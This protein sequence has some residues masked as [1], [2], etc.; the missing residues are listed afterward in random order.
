MNEMNVEGLEQAIIE[1]AETLAS[2]YLERAERSRNEILDDAREHLRVR[3]DREVQISKQLAERD[4]A[5]RIQASELKF[6]RKLDMLR[7]SLVQAVLAQLNERLQAL[8]QKQTD[9]YRQLLGGFI[10]E[11][12]D[13]LPA[14]KLIA[15]LNTAD[16]EALAPQWAEFVK[17]YAGNRQLALHGEPIETIG[18]ILIS[19]ADN[20][21]RVDNRFEG[22]IEHMSEELHQVIMERLFSSLEQLGNLRIT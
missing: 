13:V 15:Y 6:Q 18:G 22:R 3:E 1:R 2:E 12:C 17:P 9:D 4:Y 7:W 5:R 11:A 19:D 21:V 14:K 16:H 8:S 10:K 20:N